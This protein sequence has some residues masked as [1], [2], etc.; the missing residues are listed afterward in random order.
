MAQ[1]ISITTIS[2]LSGELIEDGKAVTMTLEFKGT[3]RNRWELDISH[4]EAEAFIASAQARGGGREV[5]R[6]GRKPGSR[7]KP[8]E[9]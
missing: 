2:D 4:Q 1:Q 6:R 7:N 8:K 9:G 5:R 3:A